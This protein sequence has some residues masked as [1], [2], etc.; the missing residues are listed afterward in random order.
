M[1][2]ETGARLARASATVLPQGKVLLEDRVYAAAQA[3]EQADGWRTYLACDELRRVQRALRT[4][5][6]W[7]AFMRFARSDD[8][9]EENSLPADTAPEKI[10]STAPLDGGS[11]AAAHGDAIVETGTAALSGNAGD[12]GAKQAAAAATVTVVTAETDDARPQTAG[13]TL[14]GPS[15]EA[16]AAS[17]AMTSA[18]RQLAAIA[19]ACRARQVLFD[20]IV[21]ELMPTRPCCDS[22]LAK[23]AFRILARDLPAVPTSLAPETDAKAKDAM[24]LGAPTDD[25]ATVQ[26]PVALAVRNRLR[27]TADDDDYDFDEEEAPEATTAAAA[28]GSADT[29]LNASS[30]AVPVPESGAVNTVAGDTGDAVN[31]AAPTSAKV[32]VAAVQEDRAE[33]EEEK[34]AAELRPF[35]RYYFSL[36]EDVDVLAQHTELMRQSGQEIPGDGTNAGLGELATLAAKTAGNAEAG[37]STSERDE[38]EAT[39]NGPLSG[40]ILSVFGSAGI[41]HMTHL[42]TAIDGNRSAISLT[43]WEIRS[44]LRDVRPRRSKWASDDKV[45]QEEL[46]EAIEHALDQLRGYKPYS[47]PFLTKV[48]RRD[49]PDYYD[50]IKKPMDFGTIAKKMKELRYQGKQEFVD[51]IMQIYKNCFEYNTEPGNIYRKSALMMQKKTEKLMLLVPDLVVRD[52]AEVEAEEERA[53]EEQM[54]EAR[55]RKDS[56]LKMNGLHQLTPTAC[57]SP[58]LNYDSST[59]MADSESVSA[60]PTPLNGSTHGAENAMVALKRKMHGG[61]ALNGAISGS[62][63]NDPATLSLR[64]PTI[65]G[66]DTGNSTPMDVDSATQEGASLEPSLTEDTEEDTAGSASPGLP[67]TMVKED[68]I[69]TAWRSVTMAERARIQLFRKQSC[70]APFAEQA[71]LLRAEDLMQKFDNWQQHHDRLMQILPAPAPTAALTH[72]LAKSGARDERAPGSQTGTADRAKFLPEYALSAGIPELPP[73]AGRACSSELFR[74][75]VINRELAERPRLSAYASCQLPR[76]GLTV[77]I[78]ESIQELKGIRATHAKILALK[79]NVTLADVASTDT[80]DHEDLTAVADDASIADTVPTLSDEGA[81]SMLERVSAKLAAHSGFE[82]MTPEALCVLTE[83]AADYFLN[84]GKCLRSYL[85]TYSKEMSYEEI[86]LHTLHENGVD[87]TQV[88]ES[89][90]NEHVQRN[91]TKLKEV[92]RR[93]RNTH[94]E[95]VAAAEGLQG[96]GVADIEADQFT[97]GDVFAE[98][99]DDYLGLRELG[100]ESELRLSSLKIPARL[101]RGRSGAN[102]DGNGSNNVNADSGASRLPYPPPPLFAPVRAVEGQIGMLRDF[103]TRKLAESPLLLDEFLPKTKKKAPRKRPTRPSQAPAA[104]ST[105][106]QQ[107]KRQKTEHGQSAEAAT[108]AATP[109]AGDEDGDDE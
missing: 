108:Q 9:D 42:L 51:D 26:A 41:V 52:R 67:E 37:G 38:H 90:V 104:E 87:D 84:L 34:V 69:T 12:A 25:K 107:K 106:T 74:F 60:R 81:F 29:R 46:Y 31:D 30:Q 98:L 64:G 44:L 17:V 103:F 4:R 33:K 97:T 105:A 77:V 75:D 68:V 79:Q 56:A 23:G 11:T 95:L 85:D 8:P 1:H 100:L 40:K 82:C 88:L 15:G 94:Q 54:E 83:S 32:V 73:L 28:E 27:D 72:D 36:E 10:L 76:D 66:I 86:I 93:L 16:V 109:A 96:E 20:Q 99:E 39:Q 71:A 91:S 49:A 22:V 3:L 21:S 47:T 24:M 63:E 59:P 18:E 5:D 57:S 6:D 53:G 80:Q 102:G 2:A 58:Q 55:R 43:D 50:V 65:N 48:S 70:S 7:D 61:L 45:N 62:G 89:Y 19:T 35:A 101:W 78:D 92:G 14:D 13:K